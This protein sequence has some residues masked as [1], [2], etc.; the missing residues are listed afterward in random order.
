MKMGAAVTTLPFYLFTGN[1]STGKK[2]MN[3][4]DNPLDE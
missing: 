4:M 3:N 2:G 1:V